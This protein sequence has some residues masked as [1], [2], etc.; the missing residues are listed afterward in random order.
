MALHLLQEA[1]V[2]LALHPLDGGGG[3]GDGGDSGR[4]GGGKRGGDEALAAEG[5]AGRGLPEPMYPGACALLWGGIGVCDSDARGR[6]Q[7]RKRSLLPSSPSAIQPPPSDTHMQNKG[8]H[9]TPHRVCFH[10]AD[11]KAAV[12]P[13]G[14]G[15]WRWVN[16]GTARSPKW[17]YVSNRRG[18]VLKVRV[19]VC[20]CV[21]VQRATLAGTMI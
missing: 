18:D 2:G 11:F 13:R 20:V 6:A 5:G 21:C 19:C 10:A 1:A 17:G 4:R 15:A 9:P 3:G 8:N 12:G 14:A 7:G 16:E